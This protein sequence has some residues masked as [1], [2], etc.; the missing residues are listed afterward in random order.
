[1][2]CRLLSFEGLRAACLP[3]CLLLSAA[4]LG[5]GGGFGGDADYACALGVEAV[6]IPD[7]HPR[8]REQ[9]AY[10]LAC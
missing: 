1:M 3:A 5:G 9:L 10:G 2:V 7:T 4:G 6:D 8:Y